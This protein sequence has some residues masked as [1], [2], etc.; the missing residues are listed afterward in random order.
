P[1]ARGRGPSARRPGARRTLRRRGRADRGSATTTGRRTVRPKPRRSSSRP[2]GSRSSGRLPDQAG[3]QR[4]DP[5]QPERVPHDGE[6]AVRIDDEV[7]EEETVVHR[8]P[9]ETDRAP[10][11][12]LLAAAKP[13]SRE[14]DRTSDAR[15]G[16]Q[17][18]DRASHPHP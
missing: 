7:E 13:A 1:S 18:V 10:D 17:K 9:G 6:V 4:A 16:T 11:E 3:E 5:D 2:T 15:Q 12:Q 14:K 8:E